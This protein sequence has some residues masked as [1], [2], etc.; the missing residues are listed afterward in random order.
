MGG[1]D[2]KLTSRWAPVVL[3]F[4]LILSIGG[5]AIAQEQPSEAQILEALKPHPTKRSMRISAADQERAADDRR[6]IESLMKKT[7]RAITIDDRRKVAE[8]AKEKP[9]ID[10]EITFDYNS[11]KISPQAMPTLQTLGRALASEELNSDTFLIAGHTDAAGSDVYNQTLSERRAEAVKAFLAEH[12]KL[13]R[14]HLLAIG[15]GKTQLKN[16]ADPLAAEN[17]RVQIVNTE[18]N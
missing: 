14:E 16:A 6:F 7:S 1:R 5:F 17:R 15:F 13:T 11:A 10:L 18:I 9:N 8:L 3:G 12:F 2:A 4:T